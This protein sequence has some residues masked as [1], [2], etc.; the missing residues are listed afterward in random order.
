MKINEITIGVRLSKHY[1]SFETTIT[2]TVQ[3]DDN[4][5]DVC[6]YVRKVVYNQTEL[7]MNKLYELEND[8]KSVNKDKAEKM[9]EQ[10]KF[11]QAGEP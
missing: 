11:G 4:L 9:L 8:K 6:D 5:D 10:S 7:T 2:A 3:H 1:N